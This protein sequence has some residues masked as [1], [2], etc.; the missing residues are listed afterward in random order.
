MM[1]LHQTVQGTG[2]SKV[3]VPVSNLENVST[4]NNMSSSISS[5]DTPVVCTSPVVASNTIT[6]SLTDP[7]PVSHTS[8]TVPLLIHF[9]Q[10][11]SEVNEKVSICILV[12]KFY[13][14]YFSCIADW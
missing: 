8:L 3:A 11:H 9:V 7:S 6:T 12:Y 5:N 10:G 13:P 2:D 4:T 1:L 14:S